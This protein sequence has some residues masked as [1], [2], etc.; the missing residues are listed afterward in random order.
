MMLHHNTIS[1]DLYDA[2]CILWEIIKTI[3]ISR[4]F[5]INFLEDKGLLLKL[6]WIGSFLQIHILE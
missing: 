2:F 1:L 5:L 4:Y 6:R 3:S